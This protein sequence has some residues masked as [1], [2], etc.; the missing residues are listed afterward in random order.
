MPEAGRKIIEYLFLKAGFN[1]IC[2][3][4]DKNNPKSERVMQKIGKTYE[5]TLRSAGVNNQGIIDLVWY[6][7]LKNDYQN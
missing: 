6:S 7:F 4:H 1:R 3:T 2:A 5:G